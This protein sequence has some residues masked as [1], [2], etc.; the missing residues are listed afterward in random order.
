MRS[1]EEDARL[2]ALWRRAGVAVANLNG[3]GVS[4]PDTVWHTT[5]TCE[6]VDAHG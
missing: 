6:R 3:I 2:W 5:V 1:Q 4:T